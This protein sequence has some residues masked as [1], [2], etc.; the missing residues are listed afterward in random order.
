[1]SCNEK[2]NSKIGCNLSDEDFKAWIKNAE[3][4]PRISLKEFY[5]RWEK[6]KFEIEKHFNSI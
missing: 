3:K 4:S 5:T 6:K 1:M 2:R